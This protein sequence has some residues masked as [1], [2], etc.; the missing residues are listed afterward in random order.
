MREKW[1]LLKTRKISFF[2]LGYFIYAIFTLLFS[3]NI[4]YGLRAIETQLSLFLFPVVVVTSSSI[5]REMQKWVKGVFVI[6]FLV[7]SITLVI[8]GSIRY[9]DTRELSYL[10]YHWLTAPIDLHAIYFANYMVLA[11]L[12]LLFTDFSWPYPKTIK[13]FG[14]IVV[15]L[16]VVMLSA[17]S[18][19]M[20]LL[21]F[22][23]ILLNK[24][25]AERIGFLNAQ[26]ASALAALVISAMALTLPYTRTKILRT[27]DLKYEMNYPDSSWNSVTLR[28]AK[29]QCGLDI[30]KLEPILGVGIGDE[31][32]QV[33]ESY[34][35]HNFLEGIRC[36]YNVH[37]QYLSSFI[38]GGVILFSLLVG[39][40]VVPLFYAVKR[41]DF[42]AV[43]F[44]LL[45]LISFLTENFINVQK[46]SV[47]FSFFYSLLVLREN[48]DK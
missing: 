5:T 29:W 40:L 20:F 6:W 3:R 17:L 48:L 36:R 28:L 4:G 9:L 12:F 33:M 35:R 45:M 25:L 43:S 42:L 8:I 39:A 46:G 24:A 38:S 47:F 23:F 16:I 15:I 14:I 27:T 41:P 10:S 34:E 11:G 7:L 22:S 21:A 37:N 44:L 32:D 19:I 1:R 30:I 13:T 18:A 2:V 26:L 31:M